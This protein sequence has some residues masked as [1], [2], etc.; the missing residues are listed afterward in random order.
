MRMDSDELET[1]MT[2]VS[3]DNRKGSKMA[4]SSSK[5]ANFN[6]WI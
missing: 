3:E 5:Q 1:S 6:D 2:K 4:G